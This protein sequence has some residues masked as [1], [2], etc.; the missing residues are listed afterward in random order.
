M[1]NVRSSG[2]IIQSKLEAKYCANDLKAINVSELKK[3]VRKLRADEELGRV[4]AKRPMRDGKKDNRPPL[5][6][7]LCRAVHIKKRN[8]SR[9]AL[10]KAVGVT[11]AAILL[12]GGAAAVNEQQRKKKA[13][14]DAAALKERDFLIARRQVPVDAATTAKIMEKTRTAREVQR[15]IKLERAE[16]QLEDMDK[17]LNDAGTIRELEKLRNFVELRRNFASQQKKVTKNTY[18]KGKLAGVVRVYDQ[19]LE[20]IDLKID[21]MTVFQNK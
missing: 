8:I 16:K 21:R 12:G 19:R 20:M 6:H 5:R 9:K 17:R 11:T 15:L 14:K 4:L 18:Q 2:K 3:V 13:R 7:E 10:V 1:P